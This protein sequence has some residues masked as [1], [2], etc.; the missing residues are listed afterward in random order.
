MT[1]RA[2]ADQH[3]PA[4][5]RPAVSGVAD[6][7]LFGRGQRLA[8]LVVLFLAAL[9]VRLSGLDDPPLGFHAARQYRSFLIARSYYYDMAANVPEWKRHVARVSR[10]HE[11]VLEPP[12][13][14]NL[15][16]IGYHIAGGAH[17]WIPRAMSIAFWLIGGLLLYRL[18]A[19]LVCP[20]GAIV[21][22]A[23]YLFLPFAVSAS[24]SFQP[25]PLMVMLMLLAVHATVRYFEEPSRQ[26]LA[27]ATASTALAMLV[28]PVC[29]FPLLAVFPSIALT[30]HGP[31]RVWRR[32]EIWFFVGLSV[33]PSAAYYAY[34]T[35]VA[36]SLKGQAGISFMP[37]MIAD[38]LFWRGWLDKLW[39]VTGYA[40][41]VAGVLGAV[42]CRPGA[43]RATVVSLW[44]GYF[45][46]GLVFTYHI[47]THDYYH[48]MVI[49]MIGLSLAP[50]AS[51]FMHA[52]RGVLH[53]SLAR[54]TAT[55][56]IVMAIALS[57]DRA[58]WRMPPGNLAP[59]LEMATTVGDIVDHSDKTIVLGRES[60]RPL[61][62]HAEI[63]GVRW[64]AAA[65]LAAQRLRG[66][67]SQTARER[68]ERLR[69]RHASEYFIV[70]HS[71][72]FAAQEDLRQLLTSEFPLLAHGRY[73]QIFDLRGK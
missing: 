39:F 44:G 11:G 22:A 59:F 61:M 48:L 66:K 10:E 52:L 40:A 35:F 56:V 41:I 5:M 2:P 45:V 63:A 70:T 19:R 6:G 57:A 7:V 36:G 43:A 21:S 30:R 60:G 12:V 68:L 53:I 26:G 62:Y 24:R 16:A 8:L 29:A 27:L 73:Y 46:M 47:R 51:L 4:P 37:K 18:A 64:P 23:F 38:P 58:P 72:G 31:A 33:V 54:S 15:A 14:E 71:R 67:P 25:D 69:E 20:D 50:L 32:R 9:G 13:V 17:L 42:L 34:G 49:A 1:Q 65:D 55:V 28:K 3:R